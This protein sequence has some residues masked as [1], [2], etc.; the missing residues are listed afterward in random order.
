MANPTEEAQRR[1]TSA[2]RAIVLAWNQLHTVM[3]SYFSG[4]GSGPRTGDEIDED[5]A[6]M[7]RASNEFTKRVTELRRLLA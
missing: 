4:S 5:L 2:E 6:A 1:F 7:Q 3:I